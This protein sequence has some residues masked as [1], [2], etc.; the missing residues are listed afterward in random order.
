MKVSSF[1]I[2]VIRILGL[3]LLYVMLLGGIMA[4]T[5]VFSMFS[6]SKILYSVVFSFLLFI[7]LFLLVLK[8]L[9]LHP[10]VIIQKFR[11][12]S[13]FEEETLQIS[14]DK[15]SMIQIALIIIG[16]L[17]LVDGIPGFVR[18]FISMMR[19]DLFFNE[20][21]QLPDLIQHFVL[22]VI[23]FLLVTRSQGIAKWI[24]Q[25]SIIHTDTLD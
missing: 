5:N 10:I 24:E 20:S 16:G 8:Y 2:I 18:T 25:K 23:G 17:T 7:G 12:T 9:V 21:P 19:D 4:L 13:H 1:W 6:P 15:T 3:Y 22:M 14:S 11:L